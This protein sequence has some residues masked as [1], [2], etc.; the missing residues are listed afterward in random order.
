[1]TSITITCQQVDDDEDPVGEPF[2]RE[3]KTPTVWE[4]VIELEVALGIEI[5]FPV[6]VNEQEID[7]D[8][9]EDCVVQEGDSLFYTK[10]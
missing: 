4:V 3:F 7:E 5:M 6:K 8:D 1:M 9:A 2:Q 10:F